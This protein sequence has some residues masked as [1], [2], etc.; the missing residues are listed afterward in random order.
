MK[1]A[2]A[3]AMVLTDLE[4]EAQQGGGVAGIALRAQETGSV[5]KIIHVLGG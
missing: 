4:E 5:E 2:V 1:G 3:K